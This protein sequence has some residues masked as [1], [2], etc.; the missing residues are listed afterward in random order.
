ME[1]QIKE[2]RTMIEYARSGNVQWSESFQQKVESIQEDIHWLFLIAGTILYFY[3]YA[4][5]FNTL[6][7]NKYILQDMCS[8]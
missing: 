1:G 6:H 5:N 7:F 4:G 3:I 2:M 8:Q